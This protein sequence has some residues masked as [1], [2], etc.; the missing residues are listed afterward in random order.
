MPG[1]HGG[2]LR[3]AISTVELPGAER[4]AAAV[5][6]AGVDMAGWDGVAFQAALG[7]FTGAGTFD[8]R[9]VESENSNF[10]G[11]VNVSG[12]AIVQQ[13]N[14]GPNVIVTIDVYRPTNRYV[15]AVGTVAVNNVVYG[16]TAIRYRAQG[17]TPVDLPNN[18]QY[19]I[20]RAN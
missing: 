19:V 5:N 8:M 2:Y 12:A 18:S 17:R 4:A 15:R 20:V 13:A 9:V 1:Y 7:A 16:V 14:T 6:G 3:G 10:S 11:A